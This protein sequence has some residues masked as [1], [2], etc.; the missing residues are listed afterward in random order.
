MDTGSHH[1]TRAAAKASEHDPLPDKFED[2]MALTKRIALEPNSLEKEHDLTMPKHRKLC[3]FMDLPLEL[4]EEVYYW[5]M[6][7]D[8]NKPRDL[9]NLRQPVLAL[10]SVQI[11]EEALRVFVKRLPFYLI[12]KSKPIHV[13]SLAQGVSDDMRVL[14]LSLHPCYF[15]ELA[16][17]P[18][19]KANLRPLSNMTHRWLLE[20]WAGGKPLYFGNIEIRMRCRYKGLP[21]YLP[22]RLCACNGKH[23]DFLIYDDSE[24]ITREDLIEWM[25]GVS[26][27]CKEIADRHV[28]S[29]GIP[30]H[31]GFTYDELNV[32]IKAFC[33]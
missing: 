21:D 6:Q 12:P 2:V 22:W 13:A 11:R 28:N 24:Y 1:A 9:V 17:P 33:L 14:I 5:A 23:T 20:G 8:G 10:V 7:L 25:A 32:I 19:N 4:R 27:S 26:K 18:Y 31:T 16:K 3:N 29:E 30:H 15:K